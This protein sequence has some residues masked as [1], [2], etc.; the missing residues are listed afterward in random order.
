MLVVHHLDHAQSF[1]IVW[2]L[3]ELKTSGNGIDYELKLYKR[4]ERERMAPPEYKALS[5]MGTAPTITN[6]QGLVMNESNAIIEYILDL[7]GEKGTTSMRP[8]ASSPDRSNFLFWFHAVQ[9]S[10]MPVLT[11]D[12]VFRQAKARTPCPLSSVVG[13]VGSKIREALVMPRLRNLLEMAESQ[14]GKAEFLAGRHL[15]AADISSIYP[16]T[17]AFTR[18]PEFA[19]T[20][21]NC[22]KW[23]D[24]LYER[25]AFKAAQEKVGEK[26]GVVFDSE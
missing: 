3:E 13:L 16:F 8:P 6:S 17:S 14:L 5:P 9:G 2:L 23:L 21:P 25:D 24:R 22:K 20:Y 11:V 12:V 19:T 26:D 4:T 15:T 10:M 1:R 7:A 18:Y